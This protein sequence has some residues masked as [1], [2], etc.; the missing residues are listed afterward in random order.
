MTAWCLCWW[1]VLAWAGDRTRE[2]GPYSTEAACERS[3]ITAIAHWRF[4]D[5]AHDWGV[6]PAR[7]TCERR[8]G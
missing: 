7:W 8:E 5:F 2:V 1:L 4:N 3:A 6:A